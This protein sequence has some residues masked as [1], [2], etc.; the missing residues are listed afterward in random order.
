MPSLPTHE[1]TTTCGSLAGSCF[2]AQGPFPGGLSHLATM[3]QLARGLHA[4]PGS[5][6]WPARPGV[7]ALVPSRLCLSGRRRDPFKVTHSLYMGTLDRNSGVH[8][9]RPANT[10]HFNRQPQQLE[11]RLPTSKNSP[12]GS[13]SQEQNEGL[14]IFCCSEG[15]GP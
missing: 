4:A 3:S 6:L 1:F 8:L 11:C 7:C 12:C 10:G 14:E 15:W 5:E 9:P 13:W 2:T